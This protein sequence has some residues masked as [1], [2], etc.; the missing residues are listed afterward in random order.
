MRIEEGDERTRVDQDHRPSFARRGRHHGDGAAPA[1][2]S[3]GHAGPLVGDLPG[4]PRSER[5]VLLALAV[6]AGVALGP[7]VGLRAPAFESAV[8]NRPVVP[9]LGAQL[10]PGLAAGLP[11]GM[12][13]SV[14]G[15]YISASQ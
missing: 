14:A 6:W 3:G 8:T 4:E 2:G 5:A 1:P 15:R 13:L 10:L 9:A 12:L 11:G 7:A